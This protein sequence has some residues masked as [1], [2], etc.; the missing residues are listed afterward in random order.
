MTKIKRNITFRICVALWK[1][2][3]VQSPSGAL[4]MSTSG[5]SWSFK[6]HMFL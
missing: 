5:N 3:G 6:R 1:Y 2:F 4:L